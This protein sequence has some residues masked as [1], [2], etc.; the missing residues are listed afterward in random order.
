MKEI[1]FFCDNP[2]EYYY[3]RNALDTELNH[4]FLRSSL[5]EIVEYC[6]KKIIDIAI[7]DL[8]FNFSNKEISILKILLDKIQNIIL[9]VNNIDDDNLINIIDNYN[10]IVLKK[11]ILID[12]LLSILSN[13]NNLNNDDDIDEEEYLSG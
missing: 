4:T 3:Y 10:T 11:P 13:I 6:N 8:D 9:F 7:I 1:L 5:E 2:S 12:D